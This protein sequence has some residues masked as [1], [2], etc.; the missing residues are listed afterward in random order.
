MKITR[1]RL[2]GFKSFVDVTEL[3]VEPGRSGVVGPNGCG[4]SNLVEALRWVMGES[5]PK[6]MRGTGMDDMIFSGTASRPARNMAEVTLL[7]DN[8]KRTAPAQF[9]DS[10]VLEVSRR[11]ERELGS[12]YRVNGREVRARDVQIL[13]ADASTGAHSPALVRQGQIGEIIA[14]KP[15]DRRRLLEEAAGITGLHSRRHEAELRLRAAETNITRLQDVILN[16]ETQLAGL[17]R[18]ARQAT[19]YRNVAAQ[20]RALE[21][22]LL[23]RRW[24]AATASAAEAESALRE[25]DM[26][27]ARA[28]EA[29]AHASTT[30][31]DAAT[32]LPAL[33]DAEARAAAALQRLTVERERLD[34]DEQR[35]AADKERV[36]RTLADIAT[37]LAQA[38]E[39]L[40]DAAAAGAKLA[41]EEAEIARARES[42]A[43]DIKTAADIVEEREAVRENRDSALE[44]ATKQAAEAA[45]E[46]TRLEREIAALRGRIDQLEAEIRHLGAERGDLVDRAT[47]GSSFLA[48][49]EAART[50]SLA[51]EA[52]RKRHAEAEAARTA[53]EAAEL[54]ERTPL[55]ETDRNLARLR[56]EAGAL[57]KLVGAGEGALFPPVIDAISVTPGYE[58]ALGAAL[59]LDLDAPS[60]RAAPAH[61]DDLG[62]L[63]ESPPLPQGAIALDNFVKAP[64]ALARRLAQT[65]VVEPEVGKALQAALK[66]GQ[67]LV[68]RKGDFWRWDG[69]TAAAD[70]ESHAAKR[71]A[72]RNRLRELDAEMARAEDEAN[73]LRTRYH[74]LRL[75]A[76]TAAID[77]RACLAAAR[78]ADARATE[79]REALAALETAA[80]KADAE[81]KGVDDAIARL[82]TER[83]AAFTR[84]STAEAEW[85][86]AP[87]PEDLEREVSA[88][89]EAAQEAR[90][91][92]VEA[93]GALDLL[94]RAEAG[95]EGRL[96]EIRRE[97]TSW[98]E[99]ETRAR[100]QIDTLHARAAEAEAERERLQALPEKIASDRARLLF[101]LEEAE[102]VRGAAADKLAEA[103]QHLKAKDTEAKTANAALAQTREERARL[104]AM[105]AGA[106]ERIAELALHIRETVDLTPEALVAQTDEARHVPETP[107]EIELKLERLKR[108]RETLG[109][110][111]LRADAEAQEVEAQLNAMQTEM[112]DLESAIGKLRHAIGKLNA[113]GRE[114]LLSA[115]D[116][117]N[118]HF[119]RLFTHLF[120]GGMAELKLV[121]SDD[122]LEAG[123]EV[124]ARP[125]GKRL[126]VMTLLSGGEQALTAL[127]LIFAVF[128]SNPAPI[129]VLDEVD[130]PLDDANVER[131]CNLVDEMTRQTDTRF[132]IITHHPL[133][134]ARMDR[135]FGVTMGERGVS[136]LVSVDLA[137]AERLR[138]VG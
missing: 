113:E 15:R 108:E 118:G 134:M 38:E 47:E 12:V 133:T 69:F 127:A 17:K 62:P 97:A 85:A 70:A 29:A 31:A 132:L 109:A 41:E 56:A 8:G 61:W 110:V 42:A 10:D 87:A 64:P 137:S 57:A 60:D 34:A 26:G 82:E 136:Q 117:V 101:M 74:A 45:A 107:E 100:T 50:A 78:D 65:G 76:E 1:L 77:E 115:F 30:Q 6:S 131:F 23:K 59:G 32:A 53:A 83:E 114:R 24:E 16:L 37:D 90:R 4:K 84:L 14:A 54:S 95:R 46:R 73:D 88:A 106:K 128:L 11:I 135:L 121:E 2:S 123:L 68:S 67:R 122:P 102:R 112:R 116:V 80:V 111:N 44:S 72:Q 63:A 81:R 13:F 55:Q 130:A 92:L 105:L 48:S 103:E 5:S 18:Q 22:A 28:T 20:I 126:Q 89:R 99:R 19:R 43:S 125:P 35:A 124:F 104:E 93:Q 25:A 27:V 3:P 36:E 75:A 9:N 79:A 94:Q 138:A 120:G 58:L 98:K 96:Q 52:A 86:A 91:T 71:L 66:P 119:Q 33:R 39:L 49:R 129:C 40:A 7:I 51:A 21:I